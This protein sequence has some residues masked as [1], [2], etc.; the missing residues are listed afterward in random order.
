[1]KELR[2]DFEGTPG[3]LD[4]VTHIAIHGHWEKPVMFYRES[5]AY[6]ALQAENERLRNAGDAMHKHLGTGFYMADSKV[7]KILEA[8]NAAKGVQP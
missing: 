5:P 1:M 6:A 8:W 2:L 3:T 7:D 4:M